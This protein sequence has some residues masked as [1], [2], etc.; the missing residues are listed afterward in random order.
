MGIL[1]ALVLLLVII[2]IINLV[3]ELTRRTASRDLP[4]F[5][6]EKHERLKQPA[7]EILSQSRGTS[8]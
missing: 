8:S 5:E 2:S 4:Y 7:M 6:R 3:A 1:S